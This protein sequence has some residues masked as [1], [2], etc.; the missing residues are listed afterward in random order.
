MLKNAVEATK[1]KSNEK[2]TE[3]KKNL[4]ETNNTKGKLIACLNINIGSGKQEKILLREGDDPEKISEIICEKYQINE[5]GKKIMA[6]TIK[7][8]LKSAQLDRNNNK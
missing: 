1:I 4:A 3:E 2:I 5:R 7:E 8:R 6:E